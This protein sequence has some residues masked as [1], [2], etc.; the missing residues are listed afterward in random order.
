[1]RRCLK[2]MF[3]NK[4]V[5]Y[6]NNN[7]NVVFVFKPVKTKDCYDILLHKHYAHR[8]PSISYAFGI[9]FQIAL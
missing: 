3:N 4:I 6:K 5:S 8:V 2:I 9:F 7:K 1:M